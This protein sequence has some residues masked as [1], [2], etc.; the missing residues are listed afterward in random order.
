MNLQPYF[1]AQE[2]SA[3]VKALKWV[4][5]PEAVKDG[6]YV[7]NHPDFEWAQLVFP[8]SDRFRDTDETLV[9]AASDLAQIYEWPLAH[10]LRLIEETNQDVNL[11]C[12][13]DQDQRK[14]RSVPLLYA[15]HVLEAQ[16]KLFLA[17]AS[18]N[19][20]RRAFYSKTPQGDVK[21]LLEAAQF[22]H[23]EEG[24]FVF[25]ASCSLYAI[26]G[27]AESNL[28]LFDAEEVAPPLSFVRRA[29]INIDTGLQ[30]VVAAI[31]NRTD[32]KLVK[33]IK[34]RPTSAVSANLCEAIGELRDKEHP[35]PVLIS[36]QWSPLLPPPPEV[37][38][39]PIR[40]I[41]DYFPIFQEIATELAPKREIKRDSYIGTVEE[42]SGE[43]NNLFQREGRVTLKLLDANIKVRVV[44]DAES[45]D[46]AVEVHK[47]TQVVVR[48][49]GIIQ[50][51]SRQPYGF[52]LE[53]FEIINAPSPVSPTSGLL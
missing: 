16:R 9:R 1:S 3:F 42:L 30:E 35:H 27:E 32:D 5:V 17:G 31:Q 51:G 36:M 29:M 6:I 47:T 25:K 43:W 34:A 52:D 23:T 53:K 15:P 2:L 50:P 44:L 18:A 41:S 24:S 39:A 10:T 4:Q 46:Q 40:I 48:V 28:P 21:K 22:R 45:Y 20:E 38:R 12:V 37:A 33:Q 19:G 7:F 13:P 11:A 49:T 8:I 26:E 14:T